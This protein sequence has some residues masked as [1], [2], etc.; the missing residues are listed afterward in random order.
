MAI[1]STLFVAT[2]PAGTYAAGDTITMS[3]IRGPSVVR[4]G[5]GAARM[6]KIVVLQ[7][8]SSQPIGYVTLKN[9]NWID[10]IGNFA[11]T[12][13][14][15]TNFTLSEN[16]AAI[17]K[18]G[19]VALQPNSSWTAEYH[20]AE[21]ITTSNDY[22]VFLLVDLDYPAV[23]A[24]ENPQTQTGTPVTMFNSYSITTT[25]IGAVESAPVW[26][27]F[28]VDVFKAGFRYLLAQIGGKALNASGAQIGF[29]SIHGAAG[30]NGLERLIPFVPGSVIALRYGLDYSTPLVKGPMTVSVLVASAASVSDTLLMET[31]FIRR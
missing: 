15:G 20:I 1:D 13:S 12:S 3:V 5:Y 2:V 6:K 17:Q 8:G 16:S 28:N 25:L 10:Q 27:D 24:V 11:I 22:E 18:C 30:Q 29:F 21:A 4:D 31:D 23:A 26:N 14:S 19:D 7:D 9:S